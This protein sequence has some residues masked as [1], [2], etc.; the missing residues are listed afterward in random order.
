[1]NPLVEN[2]RNI[3][4]INKRNEICMGLERDLNC[5]TIKRNNTES[6]SGDTVNINDKR[7]DDDEEMRIDVA[8][9]YNILDDD[10]EKGRKNKKI[11]KPIN[12]FTYTDNNILKN[13][14]FSEQTNSITN[15]ET[16]IDNNKYIS[17][18][19]ENEKHNKKIFHHEKK[20]KWMADDRDI[21]ICFEKGNNNNDNGINSI[22]S[23]IHR[24]NKKGTI[25][26]NVHITNK[27][28]N[29]FMKKCLQIDISF[30]KN[31]KKKYTQ[32]EKLINNY[33]ISIFKNIS[34]NKLLSFRWNIKRKDTLM[35][36]YCE[37]ICLT[38]HV[39]FF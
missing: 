32:N 20:Y 2:L 19:F 1:M 7:I 22:G 13:I 6:N 28:N 26:K 5:Y 38:L 8:D 12:D 3:K 9:N 25:L 16:F 18:I 15:G 23:S 37:Y 11:I 17:K 35:E 21:S 31:L 24:V 10:I 36:S 30:D 29:K 27:F 14:K 39:I 4:N 34:I 33:H